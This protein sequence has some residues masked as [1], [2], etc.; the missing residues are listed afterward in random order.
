M[1]WK[2]ELELRP[3]HYQAKTRLSETQTM[4]RSVKIQTRPEKGPS[5]RLD[6]DLWIQKQA[7]HFNELK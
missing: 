3:D 4:T 5:S 2:A 6:P 1:H 7:V